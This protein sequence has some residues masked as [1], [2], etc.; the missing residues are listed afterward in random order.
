M[1]SCGEAAL[2]PWRKFFILKLQLVNCTTHPNPESVNF[3]IQD[4]LIYPKLLPQ[5]SKENL[6]T[7]YKK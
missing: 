5:L 3:K 6:K 2:H 4:N 7:I 1:M